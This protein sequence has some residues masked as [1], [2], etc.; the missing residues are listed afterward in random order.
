LVNAI[1]KGTSDFGRDGLEASLSRVGSDE[2]RRM[3]GAL[4]GS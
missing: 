1:T 2:E 3:L 4:W